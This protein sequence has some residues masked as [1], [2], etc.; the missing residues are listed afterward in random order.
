MD[1]H[2]RVGKVVHD[3]IVLDF[4]QVMD[5]TRISTCISDLSIEGLIQQNRRIRRD[6]AVMH[7]LD[8]VSVNTSPKPHFSRIDIDTEHF[9]F[10]L[11]IELNLVAKCLKTLL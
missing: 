7:N 9:I 11:L 10:H 6:K 4:N 5:Q 8:M 3:D 2:R 1:S